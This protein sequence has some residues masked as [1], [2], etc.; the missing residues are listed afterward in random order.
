MLHSLGSQPEKAIVEIPRGGIYVV[1]AMATMQKLPG[2][3]TFP[4]LAHVL[5]RRIVN[6]ARGNG[7]NE[8][9]FVADEKELLGVLM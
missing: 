5:L 7:S 1:D 9:H 2:E 8:I 3:R 4:N 6:L